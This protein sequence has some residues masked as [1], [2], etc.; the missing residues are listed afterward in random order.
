MIEV[1]LLPVVRAEVLNGRIR[2]QLNPDH[3]PGC[4]H[5]LHAI[6]KFFWIWGQGDLCYLVALCH[7]DGAILNVSAIIVILF[8]LSLC[9][10]IG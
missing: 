3:L 8:I 5:E 9:Y 2:G 4:R 10:N 7:F 1:L 6:A